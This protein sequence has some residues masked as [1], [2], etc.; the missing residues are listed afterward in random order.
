[1]SRKVQ[2]KRR[3]GRQCK[4]RSGRFGS[5]SKQETS[6]RPAPQHPRGKREPFETPAQLAFFFWTAVRTGK[7]WVGV[8]LLLQLLLSER[9]DA[10]RRA[11]VSWFHNLADTCGGPP[12]VEVPKCNGKTTPRWVPLSR[13]MAKLLQSWMQGS[14]LRVKGQKA[15]QWPFAGQRMRQSAFLFPGLSLQKKQHR[16]WDK[17]V[18]SRGYLKQLKAVGAAIEKERDHLSRPQL[19][20]HPFRDYEFCRLGTHS[21]KRTAI[22]W[23]KDKALSTNLV[24]ALSGTSPK[25]VDQEYDTPTEARKRKAV[26]D[27]FDPLLP[28]LSGHGSRTAAGTRPSKKAAHFCGSCGAKRANAAWRF[29]PSCGSDLFSGA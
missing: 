15:R 21:L 23:M 9:G 4:R 11:Q 1:M 22:T 6:G 14:G 3:Q 7:A 19:S 8:L 13:P 29:C 10:A 26:A 27:S 5:G 16:T 25:I 28:A 17:P 20:G 12:G 2:Q 18:T 24:A